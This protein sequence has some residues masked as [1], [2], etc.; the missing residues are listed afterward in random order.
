MPR[1]EDLPDDLRD[2]AYRNCVELTDARWNSDLQLLMHALRR[3]DGMAASPSPQPELA[4]SP[5]PQPECVGRGEPASATLFLASAW[6]AIKKIRES[7]VS[8]SKPAR[9]APVSNPAEVP[10]DLPVDNV[11]FTLTGPLVLAP[12]RAHELQFWLHVEQQRSAVLKAASMLHGLPQSNLAVKSEGRTRYG[13]VAAS[14]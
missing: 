2:L 1:P 4:A 8:L 7:A 10:R 9:P 13:A 11:H 3:L 5:K 6:S 12:G 14:A